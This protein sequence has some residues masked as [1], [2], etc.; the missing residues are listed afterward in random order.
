MFSEVDLKRVLN[1]INSGIYVCDKN[2]SCVYC[3]EAY[4]WITGNSKEELLGM[5]PARVV[6][7]GL[8]SNSVATLS[9]EKRCKVS[10]V[11]TFP[12]KRT[13]LVTAIPVFA[14]N[15]ADSELQ[16]VLITAVDITA[17]NKMYEHLMATS[18]MDKKNEVL[19]KKI[20]GKNIVRESS[21]MQEVIARSLRAGFSDVP[22]I[23]T[24]ETGVGKEIVAN[25]I[26][27]NSGR[28]G[29]EMIKINCGAIPAGAYGGR[30]VRLQRGCVYR[31]QTG[32]T[33]GDFLNGES[34]EGI[35]G[36][37]RGVAPCAS[38][39]AAQGPTGA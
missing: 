35:S 15:F 12:N 13:A 18:L 20:I 34:R 30:A 24:G 5:T 3:S 10:L 22:V 27:E 11:Q 26:H 7:E 38:G 8:A 21:G 29:Y 36:R 32:R 16:W 17:Q 39:K 23:I 37:D 1:A 9:A 28:S 2:L 14:D 33:V 4:E 25:I 31:R 19:L 6:G